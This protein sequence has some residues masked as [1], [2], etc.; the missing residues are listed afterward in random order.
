MATQRHYVG[1]AIA[2]SVELCWHGLLGDGI[3]FLLFIKS[4]NLSSASASEMYFQG[5]KEKPELHMS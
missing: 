2:L 5:H 4:S 1:G 3:G